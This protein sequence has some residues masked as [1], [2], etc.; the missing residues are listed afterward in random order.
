MYRICRTSS[1]QRRDKTVNINPRI[2]GGYI[3]KSDGVVI[4]IIPSD[5]HCGINVSISNMFSVPRYITGVKPRSDAMDLICAIG[6][7]RDFPVANQ[8]SSSITQKSGSVCEIIA[9][10]S[11][12]I[13]SS[14]VL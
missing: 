7:G 14:I 3:F 10:L 13:M 9:Y 12:I 11:V 1:F 8:L 2:F 4:T 6:D 5:S